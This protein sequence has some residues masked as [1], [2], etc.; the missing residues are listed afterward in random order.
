[1]AA[2]TVEMA[3][4][5]LRRNFS[6]QRN[7]ITEQQRQEFS[8]AICENIRAL[9]V[10][11]KTA[12]IAGY[13]SFGA[14][15]DISALFP[16]KQLFLPRFEARSGVY[17]MVAVEDLKHDL[18]PGKYGIPEPSPSLP[19][20]DAGFLASQVLFLVPAV[21]CDRN[22]CRL[23]R[24]GGYYD[25]LLARSKTPPVAVI[26]SCQLSETPLPGTEHDRPVRWIVTERE[27]IHVAGNC[28]SGEEK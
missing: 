20:A 4:K 10:F 13:I 26:Y 19:A 25:R 22:G 8:A 3:K 2:E 1:M 24:G 5:A 6:A 11:Q 28:E 18:L 21:A 7:A 16:G 15:V 27:V 9:P 12:A 17:E 14:E 23:G